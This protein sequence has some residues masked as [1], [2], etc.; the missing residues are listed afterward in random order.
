VTEDIKFLRVRE[1]YGF[2]SNFWKCSIIYDGR[3]WSTSEHLYQAMK[4]LG[5]PY[6]NDVFEASSAWVAMKM[7][8]DP[9]HQ[10]RANWDAIKDQVMAHVL[11]LKFSQNRDLGDMLLAT[12]D[13]RLVE[14]GHHDKYW[15][16]GGDGSGFNRLGVV[17]ME[18]REVL[19][20][21]RA[22]EEFIALAKAQ[23]VVIDIMWPSPVADYIN[24]ISTITGMK[25]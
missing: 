21:E 22:H 2:L 12:G 20:L 9:N 1:P 23:P 19:K 8:R 11:I 7:G 6:E 5:T 15:A 18:I 10:P 25:P 4:H 13:A 17:L 24:E 14:H 16:D 3:T